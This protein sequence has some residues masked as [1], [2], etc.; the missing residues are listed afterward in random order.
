MTKIKIILVLSWSYML[1][2]YPVATVSNILPISQLPLTET[3]IPVSC[4]EIQL[5]VLKPS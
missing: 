4:Q 5:S 3:V 1:Q 2:L